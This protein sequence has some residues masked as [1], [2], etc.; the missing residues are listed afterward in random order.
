M[1]NR[2]GIVVVNTV[3]TSATTDEYPV[4]EANDV[5]GGLHSV[6]DEAERDAIFKER[7]IVGMECYVRDIGKLYRLSGNVSATG[8]E[9]VDWV[10]IGAAG[11]VSRVVDFTQIDPETTWTIDHNL[12]RY[13]EVEVLATGDVAAGVWSEPT[14]THPSKNRTILTFADPTFGTAQ[15][16]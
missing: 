16:K 15:L 12:G 11:S 13:P 6:A 4:A 10:E 9:N 14:V 8:I 2:I 3:V 5:K 1:S 7:R